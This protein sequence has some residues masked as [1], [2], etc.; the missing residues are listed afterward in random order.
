M[1]R[2]NIEKMCKCE[3]CIRKLEQISQSR[4]YWDKVKISEKTAA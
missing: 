2:L 3:H 4:I 1:E